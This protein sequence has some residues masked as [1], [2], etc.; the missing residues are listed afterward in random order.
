[1]QQFHASLNQVVGDLNVL[2]VKMHH[3]HWFIKG[4][5]FFLLH[6]KFQGMYEEVNDLYDEFAERLIMIGGTPAS[7][8][9][10][11]LSITKIKEATSFLTIEDTLMA[12]K[13]DFEYLITVFKS[14][15]KLAKAADD[16]GTADLCIE[17]MRKFEKSVW[18]LQAS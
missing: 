5:I 9:Q 4:R 16:E 13:K 8:L 11:Y 18:M 14:V 17:A 7:S 6:E 12:I 15:L 3:H 10:A 1:M 2:F